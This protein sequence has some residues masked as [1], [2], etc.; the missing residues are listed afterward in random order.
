LWLFSRNLFPIAFS[1]NRRAVTEKRDSRHV[2]KVLDYATR[3]FTM[4][5]TALPLHLDE[6]IDKMVVNR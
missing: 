6:I 5:R 3:R 2:A 4:A 1:Q